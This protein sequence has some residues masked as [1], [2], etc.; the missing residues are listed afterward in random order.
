MTD[1]HAE[2]T[3]DEFISLDS[4]SG[5]IGR[6]YWNNQMRIT[7]EAWD[8]NGSHESCTSELPGSCA[9]ISTMGDWW[10]WVWS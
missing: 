8:N 3:F 9:L 4:N 6:I 2:F 7:L 10:A 5:H 1:C